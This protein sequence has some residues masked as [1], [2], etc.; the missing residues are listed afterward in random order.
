[1]E[2]KNN[3][4]VIVLVIIILGLGG[5]ILYDKDVLGLKGDKKD[6]DTEVNNISE[7]NETD[8]ISIN[9]LKKIELE[10]S[11]EST[12]YEKFKKL[13]LKIVEGELQAYLNYEKVD[14]KGIDGKAKSFL[15]QMAGCAID[16]EMNIIVLNDKNELF[17]ADVNHYEQE[18]YLTFKKQSLDKEISDITKL[19]FNYVFSTCGTNDLAVITKDNKV[20]PYKYDYQNKKFSI[21]DLDVTDF[22]KNLMNSFIL[23]NDNTISIFDANGKY[24]DKFNEKIK[25]NGNELKLEKYYSVANDSY[26]TTDDS[27]AY[28]ISDNKLYKLDIKSDMVQVTDVKVSL[29]NDKRILSVYDNT[30]GEQTY[31]YN[32]TFNVSN[33]I[34]FEDYSTYDIKNIVYTYTAE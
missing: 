5:F 3:G 12:N 8:K 6:N 9:N 28:V 24:G 17:V 33:K 31:T 20:Y 14:V 18:N 1:M 4:L 26:L 23:H 2:K 11:D 16:S 13:E 15:Y 32:S 7:K 30:V 10:V 22:R 29:V 19:D 25:Y 27:E 21:Y 34:T